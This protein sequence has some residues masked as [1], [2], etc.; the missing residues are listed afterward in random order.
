MQTISSAKVQTSFG[1]VADIVKSGEPITITQYG[2]PT[3]LLL[4][5]KEGVELMRL[6]ASE[7]L[8]KWFDD[9]AK[10][11]PQPAKDATLEEINALVDEAGT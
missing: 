6:R 8:M 1:E 5:Y 9:R 7:N 11:A 10:D 3:M 2:R 4:P